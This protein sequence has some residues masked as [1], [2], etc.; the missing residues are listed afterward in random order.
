MKTIANTS[1][2]GKKV[3]VRCDFN[4]PLNKELQI[5]DDTRIRESLPTI[6]KLLKDGAA[7]ILMSHLGRPKEIGFEAAFSLAPVAKHLEKLLGVNVLLSDAKFGEETQALAHKLKAGEIL[8]LE[9]LRF[10]P[11]EQKGNPNFANYLASL[12]EAYVN[13][14]F[15]T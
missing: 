9:N 2:E 13:D 1:F 5:T 3:L 8:L 6:Q 12:G 11:G 14:A 7:L 4:V 10:S 15:G